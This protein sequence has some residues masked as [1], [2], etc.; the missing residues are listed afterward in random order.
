MT[1]RTARLKTH[2]VPGL[3]AR[4]YRRFDFTRREFNAPSVK[5]DPQ[6]AVEARG[7]RPATSDT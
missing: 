2:R 7:M 5:D 1:S 6:N 3:S 4:R